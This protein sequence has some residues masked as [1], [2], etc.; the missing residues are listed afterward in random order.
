MKAK[1]SSAGEIASVEKSLALAV[2]AD[3]SRALPRQP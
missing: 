2:A 1:G 3:A